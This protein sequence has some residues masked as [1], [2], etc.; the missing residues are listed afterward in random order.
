M[1]SLSRPELLP[2][3]ALSPATTFRA[4]LPYLSCTT[5]LMSG[6]L[7]TTSS[8][9]AAG[10]AATLAARGQLESDRLPGRGSILLEIVVEVVDLPVDAVGVLDPELVLVGVAAVDAHL[11]AHRQA[12]G[13]DPGEMSHHRVHG[14]HL[15]PDVVH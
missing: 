4:A 13:L 15:D 8:R 11:F 10:G 12:R 3:Q 7:M 9:G 6:S 1:G 2:Q 5:C 14:V